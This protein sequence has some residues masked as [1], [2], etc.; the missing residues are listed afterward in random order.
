MKKVLF[1]HEEDFFNRDEL[2][3][4]NSLF[5]LVFWNDFNIFQGKIQT[6]LNDLIPVP[7]CLLYDLV[8]LVQNVR[9][10][11]CGNDDRLFSVGSRCN[12]QF[13]IGIVHN[14]IPFQF[15]F[16]YPAIIIQYMSFCDTYKFNVICT[17]LK[18]NAR[19]KS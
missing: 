13:S 1:S 7:S 6:K 2:K 11:S 10:N 16:P 12:Y 9:R 14:Y 19:G 8:E 17:I 18:K 15:L 3:E 5:V 4:E